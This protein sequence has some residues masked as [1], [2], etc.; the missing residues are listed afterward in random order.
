MFF[1]DEIKKNKITR[2]KFL[3]PVDDK[4]KKHSSVLYLMTPDFQSTVKTIENP[5]MIPRYFSSYYAEK[6]VLYYINSKNQQITEASLVNYMKYE[7]ISYNGLDIDVDHVANIM[8]A[9]FFRNICTR[10]RI[11]Y[12]DIK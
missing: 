12:K 7:K 4:D 9:N 8:D 10:Y 6:S 1:L 11:N 2:K 3:L 5:L